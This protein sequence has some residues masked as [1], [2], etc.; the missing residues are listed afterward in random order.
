MRFD[1]TIVHVPRKSLCTTD[2]LSR[3]SIEMKSCSDSSFEQEVNAYVNSII[4][5]LPAT[6]AH[7]KEIESQ[8]NEGPVRQKLKTYCQEGWSDKS[9]LKGPFKPYIAVAS[10]LCVA[11]K[12]IADLLFLLKIL[13][14]IHTW[15]QGITKC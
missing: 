3:S 14:K 9:T 11:N 8:Q 1:Y 5:N 4:N 12:E 6:D 15:H 2:A 7:L 10:E 13:N